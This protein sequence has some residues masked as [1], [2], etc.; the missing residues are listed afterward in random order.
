MAG[1]RLL[2][3]Q[4]FSPND[5]KSID[6]VINTFGQQKDVSVTLFHAYTPM[7]PVEVSHSTV[8]DKLRGNMSFLQQQISEKEAGLEAIKKELVENG[9][10]ESNIEQVFKPRKK[11]IAGEILDLHGDNRFDFL[12]LSR[13]PGRVSRFFTGSVHQKVLA[14]LKDT[15]ICV[16]T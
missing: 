8:T 14:T 5:R 15:T 10:T 12:V 13:K 2:L 9:F 11:D 7:P 1:R 6:F 3:P 4:N 16:V